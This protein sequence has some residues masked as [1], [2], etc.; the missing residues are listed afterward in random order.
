V[1]LSSCVVVMVQVSSG[2]SFREKLVGLGAV[3]IGR[4]ISGLYN[5]LD[6]M[7]G[8][9]LATCHLSPGSDGGAPDD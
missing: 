8:A 6:Q 3:V 5:T 9:S 4:V 1:V 2:G 7:V